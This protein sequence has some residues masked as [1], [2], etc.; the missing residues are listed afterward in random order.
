MDSRRKFIGAMAT[1]LASTLASQR[2][3]GANDRIRIGVIGAGARGIELTH[4]ASACP[5]VELAAVADVFTKRLDVARD[6]IPNAAVFLDHRRLLDDKSIDAV[7]VATPQH[8]HCEHFVDSLDAAKHVYLEKTMA[9][10]LEH[11][12]RMRAAYRKAGSRIVQIGHQAC[13][14]G[15]MTDALAFL[16]SGQV[17]P[18]TAIQMRMF[19][20][21][22]R[23]KPQWMRPVYPD[24]T[25]DNIAWRSFLGDAPARDFDPQRYLNWR[26]YSDYSGGNVHE[27]MSQ[28]LAFW[29]RGSQAEDP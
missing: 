2:V 21:T 29:Y 14:S 26:L 3:L 27:N 4:W 7:I 18:I 10:T 22:P 5:N 20:N 1:G 11:A 12:L 13:S 17:G 8:L 25:P 24:M 6:L 28:Q 15:Q 9:F 19:R 16:A 23:G